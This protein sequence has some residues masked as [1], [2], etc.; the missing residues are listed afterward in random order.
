MKKILLL[1]VGA[2]V[3]FATHAQLYVVGNAVAGDFTSELQSKYDAP[4]A[5]E[6]SQNGDYYCFRASGEFQLSTMRTGW[7]NGWKTNSVGIAGWQASGDIMT[8]ACTRPGSETK[9][10]PPSG[11]GETY[12]RVKTDLSEIQASKDGNFVVTYSYAIKGNFGDLADSWSSLPEFD[13]TTLIST[14]DFGSEGKKGG[15]FGVQQLQNG[16]Q[17]GWFW[18]ASGTDTDY[19]SANSGKTFTLVKEKDS[20]GSNLALKDDKLYGVV[21]FKLT[22]DADGIPTNL[23]ITGG[24]K[25]G[26]DT[27]TFAL[28]NGDNKLYDFTGSNP[29]EVN[30]SIST[31]LSADTPLCVKRIKNGTVENTYG[32]ANAATYDGT[33][34]DNAA[35]QQDGASLVLAATLEGAVTFTLNVTDN[36]PTSLTVSGGQLHQE[37]YKDFYLIGKFN[38][39]G[40]ADKN[41]QFETTDGK[42]YTYT[43][44]DSDIDGSTGWKINDGTWGLDFAR[45]SEDPHVEYNI[46]YNLKQGTG[47]N[48]NFERVIPAGAILTFTYNPGATSTLLIT[49]KEEPVD[50]VEPA[51]TTLYI[52]MKYDYA[53]Q[54]ADAPKTEDDPIPNPVRCH[55]YNSVTGESKYDF[56]SYEERMDRESFRYSLWKFE[57]TEEDVKKYDAVDFYIYATNDNGT[58]KD[59]IEYRS[60][61]AVYTDEDGDHAAD[62]K[63]YDKTNW[64]RFIYATATL[65]GHSP[66]D[67]YPSRYACQ[68]MMSFDDFNAMN[69]RDEANGGR[70]ALYLVGWGVTFDAEDAEG[71]LIGDHKSLPGTPAEAY[72]LPADNGC[73]YLPVYRP[74]E[75]V[76]FKVSFVNVA[77]ASEYMSRFGGNAKTLADK[78]DD[79]SKGCP[80]HWATFDLGLVGVD[81]RFDYSQFPGAWQ[82]TY[83]SGAANSPGSVN[84]EVNRSVKYN[85]VNQGD[86]IVPSDTPKDK[87]YFVFDSHSECMSVSLIDFDPHPTIV[88]NSCDVQTAELSQD[89][90]ISLHNHGLHLDGAGV[91]GHVYVQNV[92][93]VHGNVTITA[94]VGNHLSDEGRYSSSYSLLLDGRE[95]SSSLDNGSGNYDIEFL[96]V[97]A[98]C[99]LQ[100]RGKYTNN[101]NH[102]T[103][104]SRTSRAPLTTHIELAA[105]APVERDGQYVVNKNIAQ[106]GETSTY[107]V[108]VKEGLSFQIEGNTDR[109]YYADFNLADAEIVD[110]KHYL[111]EYDVCEGVAEWVKNLEAEGNDWFENGENNDWSSIMKD[112][113][114]MPLY[115]PAVAT[116][117]DVKELEAQVIEGEIKAVYP[118]LIDPEAKLVPVASKAPNRAATSNGGASVTIEGKEL[119]YVPMS[120]DVRINVLTDNVISG[121][122]GVTVDAVAEGDVEYYTISG[123]RVYGE[124]APGIYLRRQGNTVAKVVIR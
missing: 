65:S 32:L 27:Y 94:A 18:A 31:P 92:N 56:G 82:P 77:S 25:E 75:E 71:N 15:S 88:A 5:L 55:I 21:T 10:I 107:G 6:V 42:V 86:W 48:G 98:D 36:V 44:G 114:A 121:V 26:G 47:E 110:S 79:A 83:A 104:H 38:E 62:V 100:I 24:A 37:V 102:L 28:F 45:N 34:L 112:G 120:A 101:F 61:I 12:F 68:S 67:K 108:F 106:D 87:N 80:R 3:A 52:Q 54:A 66:E 69:E 64:T 72:P 49:T 95:L 113:V 30:Y 11:W 81:T 74:S 29:Y 4:N 23:I 43:V 124:P 115:F 9:L 111:A 84:M 51:P 7:D 105:P 22:L 96:P 16:S 39:W 73:F 2:I 63:W 70:S 76:K 50:P 57:L 117:A 91:N 78:Y 8:S 20:N 1:L 35:L 103:F 41:Y 109:Y 60:N 116:A 59:A 17:V 90:A 19:Y 122:E 119:S 14:Y 58:Y 40:L 93:Y 89:E 97:S 123:V 46:L 85:N 99:N 118:F 33:K 13:K 53:T